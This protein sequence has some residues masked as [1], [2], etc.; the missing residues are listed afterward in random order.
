M[1][2]GLTSND[3][4]YIKDTLANFANIKE[5]ILF[6]SRAL[7]THKPSSDIDI[8]LKGNNLNQT[9]LTLHGIFNDESPFPYKVDVIDY[10]TIDNAAL[11]NHIDRVGVVIF[12]SK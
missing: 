9:I 5:A 11:K 2:F 12:T 10:Q 1:Q 8:A 7:G 6:G 3:I 4:Q